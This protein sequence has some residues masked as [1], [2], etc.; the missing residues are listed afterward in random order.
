MTFLAYLPLLL[1]FIGLFLVVLLISKAGPTTSSTT[2]ADKAIVSTSTAQTTPSATFLK[3]R[4]VAIYL[5]G[6]IF[7]LSLI[8][9]LIDHQQHVAGAH[10]AKN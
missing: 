5:L 7:A 2:K 8:A 9:F 10:P 1:Y 4:Y 3:T 6:L